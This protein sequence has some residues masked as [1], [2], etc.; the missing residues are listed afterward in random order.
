MIIEMKNKPI[1]AK[2][3]FIPLLDIVLIL[4]FAFILSS[5]FI[6]EKGIKIELSEIK[7]AERITKANPYVA[8]TKSGQCFYNGTSVSWEGLEF[9]LMYSSRQKKDFVL[10]IK[11]DKNA[12]LEAVAKVIQYAKSWGIKYAFLATE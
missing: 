5:A 9:G 10:I 2:V 6:M 11:A 4:V 12:P 8:I 3:D 7:S 1:S